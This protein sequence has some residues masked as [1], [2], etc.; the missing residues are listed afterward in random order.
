MLI[1]TPKIT[2]ALFLHLEP[3]PVHRIYT[4][5]SLHPMAVEQLQGWYLVIWSQ[6]VDSGGWTVAPVGEGP[7]W[8]WFGSY[9]LALANLSCTCLSGWYRAADT[10]TC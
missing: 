6:S 5:A 3:T 7:T 4:P 1:N 8:L 10:G 9:D 2:A